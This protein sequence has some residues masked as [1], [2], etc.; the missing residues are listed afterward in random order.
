MAVFNPDALYNKRCLAFIIDIGLCT[1]A[2][3]I[4]VFLIAIGIGLFSI[5]FSDEDFTNIG[6]FI[7]ILFFI[8]K[9]GFQGRSLGKRGLGLEVVDIKTGKPAGLLQSFLR[10]I[11]FIIPFVALISALTLK[12]EQ[13]LGE[14]W[15]GTKVILFRR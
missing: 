11:P 13:R 4:G 15:A 5:K 9:D 3:C 7:S 14:G 10:N 2:A 8:F 12:A 6:R 1:A